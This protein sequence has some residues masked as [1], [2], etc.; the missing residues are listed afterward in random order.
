MSRSELGIT[1]I[2]LLIAVAILGILVGVGIISLPSDR[3]AVNQAAEGLSSDIK[4]ARFQAISR[5]TYVLV[6]ASVDDNGYVIRERDSGVEIKRVALA[7]DGRTPGV[8]LEAVDIPANDVVFDPRGIGI[9]NGPQEIV[10]SST[11]SG[12]A[13]TVAVSQQ[14]RVTTR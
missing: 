7:G 14:G 5:N 3:F 6:E 8:V 10:F 9:G 4:L 11:R 13:R 1:I 12:F 2:E